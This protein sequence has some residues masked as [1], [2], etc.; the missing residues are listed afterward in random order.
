[1]NFSTETPKN[2]IIH[3]IDTAGHAPCKAK[4]R[5]LL[6]GS[7]KAVEGEK[8]VMQLLKLGIIERV[9]PS[10]P[11]HWSSPLHLPSKPD[12]SLRPVGDYRLLNAKTVLDLYPLPN[13][14]SFTDKIAGSTIFSK[15]DM[16]KAFHQIL[17][18]PRD[19]PKTCITTPWGL[20]N[21]KRLSMGMQNSAQ[22]FQRLVDSIL[23]DTP[24]IFVYLDDILIFNKNKE[25]HLRTI[26]EVFRKLS[27]AGLT[28]SLSK[29]EFG[30]TSLDYLGYS[31]SREGIK[32]IAKKVAAIQDFP[33]PSKQKQLLGFLGALNYYRRNLPKL[34]G[35]SAA[36]VLRPLYQAATKK[37]LERHLPQYGRKKI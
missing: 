26:E 16:A 4:V 2:G 27:A 17:I 13:L 32:P 21:F 12:G 20:F 1:M 29:C 10:K 31:V 23:K 6:P 19:R 18:D 11:N 9:D 25:E 15:V 24:N 22:S 5:K 30:K 28:L 34:D 35:Q 36:D 37:L 3:R 33:E 7:H 14:R 8:A